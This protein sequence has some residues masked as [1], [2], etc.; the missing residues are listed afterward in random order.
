MTEAARPAIRHAAAFWS[1]ILVRRGSA[2]RGRLACA[3]LRRSGL[4]TFAMKNLEFLEDAFVGRSVRRCHQ[5]PPHRRAVGQRDRVAASAVVLVRG[6][7]T[8]GVG[9][10]RKPFVDR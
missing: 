1:R 10:D 4:A 8:F 3:R 2:R 6:K 9:V 7:K 5:S